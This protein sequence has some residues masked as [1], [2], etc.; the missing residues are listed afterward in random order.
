[1]RNKTEKKNK[2]KHQ[3]D[4]FTESKTEFSRGKC[5]TLSMSFKTISFKQTVERRNS[6]LRMEKDCT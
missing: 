4:R 1:M 5:K 6:A 3:G 2:T